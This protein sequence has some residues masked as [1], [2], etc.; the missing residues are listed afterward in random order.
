LSKQEVVV[1]EH[2]GIRVLL[3]AEE[4]YFGRDALATRRSPLL[5]PVLGRPAL[6]HVL[7]GLAEQRFDEVIL[8]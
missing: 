4:M 6:E 1:G 5:W 8:L 3:L 7:D 2:T